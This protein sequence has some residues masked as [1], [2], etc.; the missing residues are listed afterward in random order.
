LAGCYAI[1]SIDSVGN[2]SIF[3]NIVCVDNCPVY[4]L[5][6]TFTPNGDGFNDTFR[7]FPFCFIDRIDFKVFN[8]WGQIVFESDDPNINWNGR[9]FSGSELAEGVYYYSC[10][11]FEQRV[12]N[13]PITNSFLIS[14][15][16]E[17]LR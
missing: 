7:P 10:Q 17:L 14:G 11:V 4:E 12:D 5:P 6:N 15:Y 9:N 13:N 1:T 8:R 3:S 16:I 2:E